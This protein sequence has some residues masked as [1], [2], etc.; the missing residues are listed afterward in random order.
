MSRLTYEQSCK[1]LEEYGVVN[2]GQVPPMPQAIP[3]HDDEVLG[4]NFFRTGI[5]NARLENLTIPKTFFGR[6]ELR[7]VSF[8]DSDLSESNLCWNDFIS[9]SFRACLLSRSDLRASIYE[10]CDFTN[11]DVSG[12]DLRRA[13]FK[14]CIFEGTIFNGALLPE[15]LKTECGFSVDQIAKVRW[16]QDEGGEPEGG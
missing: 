11:C 14:S 9:V 7:E 1:L 12:S 10:K 5:E 2:P 3:K 15:R 8:A 16:T 4:V 6:S 13:S